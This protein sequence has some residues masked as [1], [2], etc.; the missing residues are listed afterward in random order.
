M[1]WFYMLILDLIIPCLMFLIGRYFLNTDPKKYVRIL[2]YRTTMSM[3]NEDTWEFTHHHIGNLWRKCGMVMA[4][5]A[6]AAMLFMI[7]SQHQTMFYFSIVVCCIE[8]I[9][10]M[11]T[12]LSTS[13]VIWRYFDRDGNRYQNR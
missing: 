6:A 7:R 4:P 13:F 11:G 2:T 5:L 8:M 12:L 3:K 9:I 1:F 10:M